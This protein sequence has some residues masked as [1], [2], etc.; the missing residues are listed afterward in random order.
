M[1]SWLLPREYVSSVQEIDPRRMLELG[2]NAVLVD[3]DNTLVEWTRSDLEP[4]VED[5][6]REALWA[7]LRVCIVSNTRH[8]SRIAGIAAK[9]GIPYVL[10]ARKP[11]RG[12]FR[13]AMELLGAV[14]AETAVVGDQMFT[15]VIGGN[16]LGVYTV[17]CVPMPGQEYPGMRMVRAVER[18]M[19]RWFVGRGR[20]TQPASVPPPPR[21]VNTRRDNSRSP[22]H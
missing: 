11:R 8:E 22:T 5:W 4:E 9:L 13:R 2:I 15:D 20:L 18:A 14:T 3:L 7:G 21:P 12:A 17:L 1:H 16:R 10:R 6:V 19:L